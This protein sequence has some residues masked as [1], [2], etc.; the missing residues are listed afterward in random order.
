MTRDDGWRLLSVGRQIE[1]LDMLSRT[2]ADG[3]EA[4][5]HESDEGFTLLLALFDSVITYRAQFQAR[6]ELPPLLHLLVLDTDNPRSLAWVA[7][8]L[9]ERLRKLARDEAAWADAALVPLGRPD[10]WSLAE[11]CRPG[12]DGA[13]DLLV[14]R[15]R[16]LADGAR[17]VSEEIG[18]KLFV[19]V[20]ATSS[21]MW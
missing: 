5:V 11:L 21:A 1:R 10:D 3:I 7:R 6:R 4:R 20:A 15:L 12:E 19:H 14:A 13:H 16:A 17:A 2:L 9:R 8:T 18:R